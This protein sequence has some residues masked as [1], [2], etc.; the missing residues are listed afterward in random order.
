M[1]LAGQNNGGIPSWAF[2]LAR[3]CNWLASVE[4]LTHEYSTIQNS[5]TQS[6]AYFLINDSWIH[7]S[8]NAMIHGYL[9]YMDNLQ[10]ITIMTYIGYI[11]YRIIGVSRDRVQDTLAVPLRTWLALDWH[12]YINNINS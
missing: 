3:E 5:L 8:V 6:L 7:I 2:L 11:Y 4:F 12:L 1:Q 9:Y 10:D